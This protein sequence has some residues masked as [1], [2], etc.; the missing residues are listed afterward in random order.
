MV[1]PEHAVEVRADAGLAALDEGVAGRAELLRVGLADSRIGGGQQRRDRRQR[2]GGRAGHGRG[3]H[4]D[5]DRA[6]LEV[7]RAHEGLPGNP[8]YEKDD[9]RHQNGGD[10]LVDFHAIHSTNTPHVSTSSLRCH[11]RV[12]LRDTGGIP[13][14]RRTIGKRRVGFN[15]HGLACCM[16]PSIEDAG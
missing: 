13:K 8:A 3:G 7:L 1:L 11:R 16:F 5:R 6:L 10:R 12:T 2:L 15:P 14:L 4:F 9:S